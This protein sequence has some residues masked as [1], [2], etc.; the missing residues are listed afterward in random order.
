MKR[1]RVKRLILDEAARIRIAMALVKYSAAVR[2]DCY[3]K[4]QPLSPEKRSRV[5][6]RA[7]AEVVK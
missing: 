3:R 6:D 2:Q 1:Q 5:L 7:R 4:P